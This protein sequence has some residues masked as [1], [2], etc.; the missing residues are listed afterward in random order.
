M[1]AR[2]A[3]GASIFFIA[4]F[5]RRAVDPYSVANNED[6]RDDAKYLRVQPLWLHQ[7]ERLSQFDPY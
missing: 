2:R 7:L 1:V 5:M 4:A 6:L 3:L